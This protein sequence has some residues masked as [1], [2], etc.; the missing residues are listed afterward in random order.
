MPFL[1]NLQSSSSVLPN[2]AHAAGF[3]L[4]ISPLGLVKNIAS[5]L[6][7]KNSVLYSSGIEVFITDPSFLN[8]G[9]GSN[10]QNNTLY[11]INKILFMP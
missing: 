6:D 8:K 2:I 7:S 1:P 4:I 3:A 11:S 9:L 5:K 10:K